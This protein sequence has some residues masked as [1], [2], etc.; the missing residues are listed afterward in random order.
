MTSSADKAVARHGNLAFG[1]FDSVS[2]TESTMGDRTDGSKDALNASFGYSS[3][4]D[5]AFLNAWMT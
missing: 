2:M 5:A 1:F 4:E 3:R